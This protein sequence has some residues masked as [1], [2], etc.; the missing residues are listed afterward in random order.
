MYSSDLKAAPIW[1]YP[2]SRMYRR[3]SDYRSGPVHPRGCTVIPGVQLT[4]FAEKKP[5]KCLFGS[6]RMKTILWPAAASSGSLSPAIEFM[7]KR[8]DIPNC[9]ESRQS[10]GD[11]WYTTPDIPHATFCRT[12]FEDGLMASSF[13]QQFRLESPAGA[14]FCDSSTMYVKRM[15][16]KH[17]QTNNWAAFAE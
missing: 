9:L 10:E 15:F 3:P 13:G 14:C 6:K 17:S 1:H 11:S 8:Q 12:C 7:Q 2:D 16:D 5:R 4:Q